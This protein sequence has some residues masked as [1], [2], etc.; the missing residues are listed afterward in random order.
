MFPK[1]ET[2][3][4]QPVLELLLRKAGFCQGV[5]AFVPGVRE[6][7]TT[8]ARAIE[9]LIAQAMFADKSWDGEDI[10]QEQSRTTENV[11]EASSTRAK[12]LPGSTEDEKRN[13]LDIC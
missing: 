4:V 10:L 3:E 2:N 11:P 7:H 13:S 5:A 8:K 12:G 6:T 1:A 9:G